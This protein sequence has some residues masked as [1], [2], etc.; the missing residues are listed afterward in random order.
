MRKLRTSALALLLAAGLG[1]VALAQAQPARPADPNPAPVTSVDRG[2]DRE[3][4]TDFG[5]IGLLGLVG[6]MGLRRRDPNAL[7]T[8]TTTHAASATATR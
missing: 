1:S 7:R 2:V 3:H 6:L 5:W 4:R 8:G